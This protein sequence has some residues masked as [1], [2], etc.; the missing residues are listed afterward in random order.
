MEKR[1]K[2]R[3]KGMGGE[4]RI[5]EDDGEKESEEMLTKLARNDAL[6]PFRVIWL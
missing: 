4:I 6:L 1:E 2:G 3:E 5:G